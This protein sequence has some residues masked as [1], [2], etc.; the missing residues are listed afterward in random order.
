M[1]FP[2]T[3]IHNANEFFSQH[4]LDEVLESDLKELFARWQEQDSAAPP[5]RLRSMAGDYFRIRERFSRTRVLAERLPLLQ[6]LAEKLF[7]ALGYELQAQVHDFEAGPLPLLASYNATDGRPLL[8]IALAPLSPKADPDEWSVLTGAPL[9]ANTG[10]D[11]ELLE[12]TDWETVLSKQVFADEHPP[13]WVLLLGHDE[14]LVIERAKW[15]RKALLRFDLPELFGPR[16]DK[17]FRA[18]AALASRESLLPVDGVALLDT[19]D[20]NSHKHAFGVSTDLKYALR[21]SIELIANEAIRHKR[22]VAKEKV[23]DRNLDLAAQL[24]GECLSFMYRLLFLFYLEARPELGYTPVAAKAYLRG[25]SLENLRDL[26][27]LSLTTSEALEGTYIHDSLKR[28]FDLIWNGFPVGKPGGLDQKFDWGSIHNNGFTIA[29]LQGHL[30]D[31]ARLKILAA[32][33]CATRS[34]NRSSGSCRWRRPRESARPAASPT[35]SS[36]STSLAPSTN[37]CCPSAASLRKKT[38]TRSARTPSAR[39]TSPP[40]SPTKT[41]CL[42]AKMQKTK[43]KPPRTLRLTT[44][45]PRTPARTYSTPP[46]S[47]PNPASPTTPTPSACSAAK[48]ASTQ[49]AASSTALPAVHAKNPPAT[50]RRKCSPSAWWST[51]SRNCCPADRKSTRLNSSH[52][53]ISRMPSSA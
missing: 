21:E 7:A 12:N 24:S 29:P 2:L 40:T 10:G 8:V 13:R 50:T 47:S 3:A 20:G 22:E 28:L 1:A 49:K 6:E 39:K 35:H 45:S 37:H 19:L 18:A 25:Y 38:S 52:R 4:Y 26:E 33:S 44:R 46:T 41:R 23:F 34:C 36:A 30:F 31:P 48:S 11:P 43:Q 53:Y 15:S 16:D 9:R 5:A 14:L 32:S 51:P 27:K 17:L 42:P